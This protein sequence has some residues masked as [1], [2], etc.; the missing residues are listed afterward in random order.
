MGQPPSEAI[1][2]GGVAFELDSTGKEIV[3]HSFGKGNDGRKPFA[4]VIDF[5]GD[6]YGTTFA[7]GT[8][9]DWGTVFRIGGQKETVL[10]SFRPRG[11]LNG[12]LIA[13]AEGNLYGATAEGGGHGAGTVFKMDSSGKVTILYGFTGTDGYA[14]FGTLIRDEYG[15]LYGTTSSGGVAYY[16]TVFKLSPGASGKWIEK[17]LHTFSG[18]DGI[19]PSGTL[20]RDAAG[21]PYGTTVWG[22]YT[23]SP[24]NV[25]PGGCG[26]VFKITP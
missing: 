17:V 24:C 21:N 22:G 9:Q 4:G 12:G 7:G 6:L 26:V 11:Y 3:L 1:T 2:K 10:H 14:P 25:Y 20:I 23:G 16:G 13:D 15:N 18:T 19:F 5:H 8:F